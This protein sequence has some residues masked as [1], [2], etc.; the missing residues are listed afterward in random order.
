MTLK[1]EQSLRAQERAIAARYIGGFPQLMV[2]WGLS[3]F[4]VWLALWPL[5]FLDM[6]PLWLGFI[7]ACINVAICYLPSHDAQHYIIARKGSRYE[8]FNELFGTLSLFPLTI[9]L[10][11]ARITHMA[12]HYYP[13]DPDRDP[14][15][16]TRA[17]NAWI[18]IW[19]SL[20][21]RQPGVNRYGILLEEW[22]TP[23]AQTALRDA[24]IMKLI[25]FGILTA[26]AW[27]GYAIEAALL[28]LIPKHVGL[29]Y[30]RFYLS[31]APH[32]PA[33]ETGRY[34]ATR[35]FKSRL[36]NIGSM[37]MQY[38]IIH[39][40][41]P[42]IPLNRTPAAYREMLPILKARG[43]DLGGLEH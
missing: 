8:W 16:T 27:N 13:N 3:N 17:P 22:N 20:V 2:F 43:C 15:Y 34:T 7:I 6:I 9:P 32:H 23:A 28:W 38:H 37:G 30:M 12:H 40:L 24:A 41:Y 31:W 19:N 26:L 35:A 25:H 42:T 21:N 4:I 33:V 18:A 11:T 5:V 1:T 29:S 10:S 14:D 36:G 39:H